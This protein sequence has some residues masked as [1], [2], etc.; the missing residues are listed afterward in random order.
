MQPRR[1]Q[2]LTCSLPLSASIVCA[3]HCY[4]R[5]TADV[6][7]TAARIGPAAFFER[8]SPPLQAC[9]ALPAASTLLW[10]GCLSADCLDSKRGRNSVSIYSFEHHA[11]HHTLLDTTTLLRA[12]ESL[13]LTHVHR[14]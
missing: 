12:C 13:R 10:I 11:T 9:R 6:L 1:A 7:A 5:C 4:A 14:A 2:P 8:F 3:F